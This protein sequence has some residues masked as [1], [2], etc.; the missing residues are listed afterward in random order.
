MPEYYLD[1][2]TTGLDPKVDKIITIQY[3]RVD[4]KTLKPSGKLTILREWESD[5]KTILQ[6]FIKDSN[7]IGGDR[8]SFVSIGFNLGFEHNFLQVRSVANGL[9]PIDILTRP[10]IDLHSLGVI[11]NNCQFRGSGLGN[12]ST[13]K[14]SG[15][16]VP[17]WYSKKEYDKIIDYIEDET[18]GFFDLF[19]W[20][21]P[22][23]P[24]LLSEYKKSRNI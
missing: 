8:F 17:I 20:I 23:L 4:T 1:I 7:I 6:Q 19:S 12:I 21:C 13:K 3:Q 2:E 22:K 18:N 24:T 10:F 14:G 16:D 5:E 9:P 15:K 11:M